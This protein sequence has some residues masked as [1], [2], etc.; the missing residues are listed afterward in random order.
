[1]DI[2]KE[3]ER[4]RNSVFYNSGD[5]FSMVGVQEHIRFIGTTESAGI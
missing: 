3:Y 1:M 5:G 2:K 4:W